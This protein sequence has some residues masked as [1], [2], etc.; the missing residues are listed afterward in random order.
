LA[1]DGGQA[2]VTGGAPAA[3]A[4]KL[5]TSAPSEPPDEKPGLMVPNLNLSQDDINQL[6][7]YVDT[8]QFAMGERHMTEP[9]MTDIATIDRHRR[10]AFAHGIL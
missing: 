9:A 2:S 6:V 1:F 8:L 4:E 3:S 5:D 10:L 7:S